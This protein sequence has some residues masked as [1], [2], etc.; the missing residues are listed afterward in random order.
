MKWDV[1]VVKEVPEESRVYRHCFEVD[2]PNAETAR[3]DFQ[4]QLDADPRN[5]Q[6]AIESVEEADNS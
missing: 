1:I 5:K 4:R 3:Q 2:S 6:F